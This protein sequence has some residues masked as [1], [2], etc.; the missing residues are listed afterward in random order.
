LTEWVFFDAGETLVSPRPSFGRAIEE[1]CLASGVSLDTDDADRVADECF[2]S[3]LDFLALVDEDRCFSVS[4]EKSRRFWTRYYSAFLEKAGAPQDS[5][6]ELSHHIY[7]ELSR[8]DRYGVFEDA[9]PTLERISEAGLRIGVI[10]N[11]EPWL[12]GLLDHLEIGRFIE[13][14]VI[15]GREGIEKPD[16]EMFARAL[17]RANVH[18]S[19]AVHVGDDPRADAE[20]A[21]EIGMTPIVIDR[22]GRHPEVPWTRIENL[23]ELPDLLGI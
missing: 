11:W 20:P 23:R 8:F 13:V 10:S 17:D 14:R 19:R 1:I 15:S 21:A 6:E 22:R 4:P 18:S 12:D 9:E 5:I 16:R 3:F 7:E 2:K